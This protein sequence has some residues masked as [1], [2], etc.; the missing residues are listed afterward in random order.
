MWRVC[1]WVNSPGLFTFQKKIVTLS[2]VLE[3]PNPHRTNS[4]QTA[5]HM[6]WLPHLT[7]KPTAGSRL[8]LKCHGTRTVKP[9]FVFAAKRT[10]PFKSAGARQF[11]RLLADEVWTSA[12]VM[13]NAACSEVVWRV[14]ATQCIRHF[15]LH[16]PSRASFCAVTF[17]QE[18][19]L[20]LQMKALYTLNCREYHHT[21]DDHHCENL[22][23]ARIL[24]LF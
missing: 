21:S 23:L 18:S 13:V 20:T 6:L 24:N 19:T 14:L 7:P 3:D 1:H 8:R 9:Y 22:F 5:V 11:S 17:Q 12:V 2:S 10:S 4:L 16:I 15:P